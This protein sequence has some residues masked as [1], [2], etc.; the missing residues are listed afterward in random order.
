MTPAR[1]REKEAA[2]RFARK[3]AESTF[4][5]GRPTFV[6]LL[7]TLVLATLL[8]GI[9]PQGGKPTPVKFEVVASGGYSRV[10]GVHSFVI[11]DAKAFQTYWEKNLGLNPLEGKPIDFTKSMLVAIHGGE[12]RTGGYSLTI[13]AVEDTKPGARK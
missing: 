12:R 5:H 10:K 4:G 2:V 11:R 13:D 9:F 8:G 7:V 1:T 6:K 3:A